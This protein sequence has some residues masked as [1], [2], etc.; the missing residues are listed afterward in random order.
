MYSIYEN[1]STPSFLV[2]D[3]SWNTWWNQA[4]TDTSF[5]LKVIGSLSA[6]WQS[7]QLLPELESGWI[8]LVGSNWKPKISLIHVK[9]PKKKLK[10]DLKQVKCYFIVSI[11]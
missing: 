6:D 9:N 8:I 5:R 2:F 4:S 1:T 11:T 10:W 3:Y 7:S